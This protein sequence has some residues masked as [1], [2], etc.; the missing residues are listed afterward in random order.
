M[1]STLG[2]RVAR[3][4]RTQAF[5]LIPFGPFAG[6]STECL[7]LFRD[8]RYHGC[9]ALAQAVIEA[10]IRHAWQ[11]K[12]KMKRTKAGSYDSNLKSLCS[13]GVI[14]IEMKTQLDVL[15]I[16]RNDFHHLNPGVE[17][18]RIKLE[19]IAFKNLQMLA[20]L[21][22]RLFGYAVSEGLIV[23]EHPEYWPVEEPGKVL[24][25]V[26]SGSQT[27]IPQTSDDTTTPSEKPSS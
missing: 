13:L 9:I 17:T 18:D 24:A 12:M 14:T 22:R 7:T 19:T 26:R 15:W 25:F 23:P 2:E 5:S 4:R 1:L 20:D 11:A 8:G 27:C 6:P 16:E 10:D 3:A 21:E